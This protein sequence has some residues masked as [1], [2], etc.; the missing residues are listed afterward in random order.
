MS[1]TGHAWG[2]TPLVSVHTCLTPYPQARAYPDGVPVDAA[3]CF[4]GIDGELS[5]QSR[6]I[7]V[8]GGMYTSN[9]SLQRWGGSPAL[10]DYSL[11]H[12]DRVA[13]GQVCWHGSIDFSIGSFG[14]GSQPAVYDW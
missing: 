8:G 3:G 13:Q 6:A 11:D 14:C 1:A 9:L 10:A 2:D 12:H 7:P 5:F 4:A